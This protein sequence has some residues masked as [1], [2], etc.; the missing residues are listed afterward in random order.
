MH[1][2]VFLDRSTL[3]AKVRRPG[4]AH[5]WREYEES[6]S[7]SDVIERLEGASVCITNKVL[8]REAALKRLPELRFI[9][10]AATGVDI[11]D[12]EY[13]KERG[14]AVSNVRG[15]A[16]HA[17]PEHAL[18]LMLALR[19][20]LFSYMKDVREGA[21]QKARQFC[22][23]DYQIRELHDSTFGIIGYGALGQ[24]ME[25]LARGIGV[26]V[27]ISEHKGAA[28]VRAG[29]ASFDEVVRESDIVSLHCPLTEETRNLIGAGEFELMKRD[30]ILINTARGG[31]VDENALVEALQTGLIGGAGFDVL[32]REPPR[33]GNPLLDL[34]LSNFI[35][36]P[37]NA[38][39]TNEAMQT[40]ADQLID[41]IEAFVR[42]EP[43][44]LVT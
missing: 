42:G 44:N 17:V 2:I 8:L 36:T 35:L 31:L 32:S 25:R 37:H 16:R 28:L 41:N 23:F 19:R 3:R 1:R 13:C 29:R 43:Q 24:A 22:L 7:E 15:Y 14:I 33:E 4:F 20:N 11:V 10:V 12:L 9:A 6:D 30:A 26:R 21:W 38:W 39:A 34:H 5:E 40:L 18:M 27:L